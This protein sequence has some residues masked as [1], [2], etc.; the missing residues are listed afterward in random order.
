MDPR[1]ESKEESKKIPTVFSP[2]APSLLHERQ[3]QL[4]IYKT[5][6]R[7]VHS[8]SPRTKKIR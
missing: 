3:F 2:V 5:K 8:L 1:A 7:K 4:F 6:A